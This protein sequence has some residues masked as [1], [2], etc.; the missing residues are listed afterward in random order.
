[1]S[2][3]RNIFM[4]FIALLLSACTIQL[5]PDYDQALV[6]GLEKANTETLTLFASV[7]EGSTKAEFGE[8]KER[9]AEIIGQFDALRM[10][11]DSRY[12]P[13]LAARLAKNKMFQS[14]CGGNRTGSQSPTECLNASPESLR[15]VI[16][17]MSEMRD[18]H[19]KDG[20]GA[21]YARDQRDEYETR[22]DQALTV[23]NAL[24]R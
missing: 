24:K 12:V 18:L 14:V 2:A 22:I 19:R 20:F 5:V 6:E 17:T 23:E 21:S 8:Y 13:P 9:Y 4:L 1:M 16:E 3:V 15:L 11:A 10:R 7:A